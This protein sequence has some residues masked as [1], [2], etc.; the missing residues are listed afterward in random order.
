MLT[1][2]QHEAVS[3]RSTAAQM[4]YC[5][6]FDWGKQL[7]CVCVLG[8]YCERVEE[9]ESAYVAIERKNEVYKVLDQTKDNKMYFLWMG[10]FRKTWLVDALIGLNCIYRHISQKSWKN[11]GLMLCVHISMNFLLGSK[12]FLSPS[13]HLRRYLQA[14]SER[15]QSVQRLSVLLRRSPVTPLIKKKRQFDIFRW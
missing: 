7:S 2:S 4:S 8:F 15:R 9:A 13:W 3:L 10:L 5:K 11:F 1:Q 12:C 6:T 14:E